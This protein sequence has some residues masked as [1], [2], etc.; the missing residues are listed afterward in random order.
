M[1]TDSIKGEK[2]GEGKTKINF[3]VIDQPNLI[4]MQYKNDITAFDDPAHTRQFASKAEASTITTCQVF[5]LL[6][7]TGIP[8]AFVSQFSGSEILMKRCQMI[9][10]EVVARRFA[11]GSILKR[12]PEFIRP[13]GTRPYKFGEAPLIEFFLKTNG[14]IFKDLQGRVILDCLDPKKGEEDPFILDYQKNVWQ[15]FHSKKPLSDP[16]ADLELIVAASQVLGP[17]TVEKTKTIVSTMHAVFLTL[18]KA[19][20]RL[21]CH[22]IDL[23]VEFGFDTATGEILVADTID[24]DSWRLRDD[25]WRELSKESFRQGEPLAEVEEKYQLVAELAKKLC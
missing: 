19:W 14:G 15:L 4:L 21:G 18:E 7:G 10:L 25:Q 9:A 17:G 20:Q 16:G 8:T 12:Q 5:Q 3:A 22:L 6:K 2:I 1:F 24:N 23:K 13:E 11:V